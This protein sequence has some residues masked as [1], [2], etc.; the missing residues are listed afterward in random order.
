MFVIRPYRR[1]RAVKYAERWAMMRNP[2][3]YDFTKIG[4]NC[5]N[6]VSQA[7]YAG[8]CMMNYTPVFGWYYITSDERTASWTG[9]DFLF[10]FLNGN[11]GL[12]PFGEEVPV[13]R[14][15][16]GD[17]V[18]IGRDGEG[19]FHS[20]LAVGRADDGTPLVAAQSLDVYGKR[21]DEYD[22]DFVRFL[23]VLGVRAL[24]QGGDG[25]FENVYNGISIQPTGDGPT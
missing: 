10:R 13:D 3:F 23:H 18:Q 17:V 21:L 7:L 12:G 11:R 22:F 20:M 1:E 4:G 6:F 5:T 8:S 14:L 2:I 16:D 9:V 15:A 25:C 24:S 19:Y